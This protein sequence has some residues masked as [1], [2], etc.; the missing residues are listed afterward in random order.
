MLR[1]H[2]ERK[3]YFHDVTGINSRLDTLQA[4]VLRVKLRHLESWCGARIECAGVY[5]ELFLNRGLIGPDKG[6]GFR[7]RSRTDLTSSTITRAAAM[8]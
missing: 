8:S 6:A 4:A 3:K 1:R 2:G 7:D 5:H